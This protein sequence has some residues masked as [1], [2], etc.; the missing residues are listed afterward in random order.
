MLAYR[1]AVGD[2]VRKGDV[3]AEVIDPLADETASARLEIRCE[4]SG[5]VLSRRAQKFVAPGDSIT[6]VVGKE[7]LGYRTGLLLED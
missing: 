3:I 6:K 7:K 1:V 4:A 5:L 2:E